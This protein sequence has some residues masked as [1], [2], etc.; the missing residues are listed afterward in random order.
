MIAS[1]RG[2]AA[3]KDRALV[4]EVVEYCLHEPF[5][6]GGLPP[7]P[8]QGLNIRLTTQAKLPTIT[9]EIGK[10]TSIAAHIPF[11]HIPFLPGKHPDD[12][13]RVSSD[14]YYG[15][16]VTPRS[17]RAQSIDNHFSSGMWKPMRGLRRRGAPSF[18]NSLFTFLARA[19]TSLA[20]R[21]MAMA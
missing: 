2:T 5:A 3:S 8:T 21:L 19:S 4:W 11:F 1:C 12:P 13:A 17:R 15:S 10:V 16:Q 18:L 7:Q 20:T 6:V 14:R 9:A